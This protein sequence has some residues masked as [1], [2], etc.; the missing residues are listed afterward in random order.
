LPRFLFFT[1]IPRVAMPIGRRDYL[2][3]LIE[4]VGEM[5]AQLIAKRRRHEG[6]ANQR[7]PIPAEALQSVIHGCERLFGMEAAHLF[8]FTPEQ[9]VLMLA[10]G[11]TPENARTKILLYAALCAEAGHAYVALGKPAMAQHSFLNALR[12]TLQAKRLYG[13]EDQPAFALETADLL[14]LLKDVPIDPETAELLKTEPTERD[15]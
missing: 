7:V 15:S 5:L 1:A 14:A 6:D 9:H 8:Q 11:E 2:L 10:E 13:V 12:L 4:Q 3:T